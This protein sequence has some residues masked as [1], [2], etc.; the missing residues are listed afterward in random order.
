MGR[1]SLLSLACPLISIAFRILRKHQSFD[2]RMYSFVKGNLFLV[3]LFL[4]EL[5]FL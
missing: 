3:Q 5:H 2:T 1:L 4:V